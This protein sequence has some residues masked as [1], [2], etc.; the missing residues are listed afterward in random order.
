MK[1]KRILATLIG[2]LVITSFSGLAYSQAALF[3]YAK[4][5]PSSLQNVSLN[6]SSSTYEVL[7][8]S[9]EN[10]QGKVL[11][12]EFFSFA[13]PHCFQ[14]STI[15]NEW[16][17]KVG[18]NVVVEKVPV[19]FGRKDWVI[20]AKLFYSLEVLG[21]NNLDG[22][23]FNSYHKDGKRIFTDNDVFDWAKQQ[24]DLNFDS[25]VS[26]YNSK[27]VALKVEKA[28]ELSLKLK[29][30][31]VPTIVVNNHYK[32]LMPESKQY[33]DLLKNT[34]DLITKLSPAKK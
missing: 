11:V 12:T 30:D 7:P 29:I 28:N 18:K 6:A 5:S 21:K 15:F 9:Q 17:A 24:K 1:N 31:G 32:M 2:S 20:L 13:C 16:S 23:V 26:T 19:T 22:S 14:F 3:D 8:G 10:P 25:F 4:S 27:E 34:S 33:N